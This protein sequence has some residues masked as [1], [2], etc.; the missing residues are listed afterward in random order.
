MVWAPLVDT[1]KTSV[2]HYDL[3]ANFSWLGGF[4]QG[5]LVPAESGVLAMGSM[6]SATRWL[7]DWAKT[8][9]TVKLKQFGCNGES[10]DGVDGC[11][12]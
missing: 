2:L 6:R 11:R 8:G 4:W 5:Q 12:R 10:I 7:F 9:N 1:L 3:G